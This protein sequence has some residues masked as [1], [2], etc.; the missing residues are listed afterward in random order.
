MCLL[1]NG[2]HHVVQRDDTKKL[3]ALTEAERRQ[4]YLDKVPESSGLLKEMFVRCLDDDPVE[5]PPI[6]EVSEMIEAIKVILAQYI[7]EGNR[8]FLPTC[9]LLLYKCVKYGTRQ[10]L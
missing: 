4:E 7:T 3:V 8:M 2:Q 9:N 10:T 6:Q 1:R 5:R